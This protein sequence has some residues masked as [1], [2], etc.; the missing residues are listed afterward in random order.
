[1]SDRSPS[2][3]GRTFLVVLFV[4]AAV[5]T[6]LL[7]AVYVRRHLPGDFVAALPY[8]VV[9][10][11]TFGLAFYALGRLLSAPGDLPDMR[12]ADVGTAL[13]LSSLVLGGILDTAG[14]TV[15]AAPLFH[16]VPAA[17]IYLGLALAGWG[18]GER[19]KVI[20]RIT[21]EG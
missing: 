12:A 4:L 14:L 1:M 17:G 13:F 2:T 5:A 16:V 8:L 20:N 18:I 7:H 6:V 9:G 3:T 19:T 15:E 11:A 10:W 21:V